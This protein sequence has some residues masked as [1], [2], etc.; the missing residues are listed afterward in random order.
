MIKAVTPKKRNLFLVLR[1]YGFVVVVVVV[2]VVIRR[3]LFLLYR[4]PLSYSLQSRSRE[5]VSYMDTLAQY[6][7]QNTQTNKLTLYETL[8]SIIPYCV[9]LQGI[10]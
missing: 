7:A 4:S 8:S 10:P 6:W 5:S 1:Y 3:T 9:Q 2:V